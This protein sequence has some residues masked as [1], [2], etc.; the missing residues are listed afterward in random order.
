MKT[1]YDVVALAGMM[2]LFFGL[3]FMFQGDPDL[4]DKLHAS[5]MGDWKPDCVPA[6]GGIGDG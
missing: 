2:V 4:W 5:A 1:L 3:F 6:D